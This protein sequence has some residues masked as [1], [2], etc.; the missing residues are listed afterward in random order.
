MGPAIHLVLF[1]NIPGILFSH[2]LCFNAR[3]SQS[4]AYINALT[5]RSHKI[6]DKNV[7]KLSHFCRSL[8]P[9]AATGPASAVS[10]VGK[11]E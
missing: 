8:S 6:E 2:Y 4:R 3:K 11:L 9:E 7:K 10:K 1:L 5:I